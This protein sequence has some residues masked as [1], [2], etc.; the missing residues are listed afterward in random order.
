M[1]DSL[2]DLLQA[3]SEAE[4]IVSRGEQKRDA[5]VQKSLDD[6]FD[7][8]QQFQQRLPE[9]HQ[10]FIDRAHERAVQTIAEMKLR[11]DER[12]KELRDLAGKHDAEAL[13]QV[14]ELVLNSDSSTHE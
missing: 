6:A 10:S 7:M 11:Y 4:A 8:E 5:I 13:H 14:I 2:K 1:D 3:E 12:N 9:M